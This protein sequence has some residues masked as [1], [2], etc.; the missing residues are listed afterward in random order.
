MRI[1]VLGASG[2]AGHVVAQYLEGQ[3]YD[4]TGLAG[5]RKVTDDTIV[6][7]LRNIGWFSEFLGDCSFDVVINCVGVLI[8]DADEDQAK[9]TYLNAWMPHYL[10]FRFAG[11]STKII[12]LSTDCVFSG[13]HGPYKEDSAYDGQLFYDRSKALGEVKNEKDLTFR[14]SIIGPELNSDGSGLFNWFMQQSGDVPGF[15]NV[16]WNGITTV[17][18]GRAINE[19][20]K[21]DLTGL[22]HLT[23][24]ESISKYDLL[25]EIK[26]YYPEIKADVYHKEVTPSNKTLINTRGD[27]QYV[28]PTYKEMIKE[29]RR[30]SENMSF[31][32][33]HYNIKNYA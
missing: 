29:M 22:Y 14:M 11:T 25:K 13:E 5:S 23:P 16:I 9:T 7:D 3:G 6:A 2:M 20:I 27:F 18:L 15:S 19:A 30:W 32:Y 17:E 4:M 21:Q 8:N 26:E 12:H 24:R 33:P 10:E 1:L 28:V 31:L